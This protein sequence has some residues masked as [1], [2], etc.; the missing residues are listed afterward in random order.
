LRLWAESFSSTG[1][2]LAE[3]PEK[4][5]ESKESVGASLIRRSKTLGQKVSAGVCLCLLSFRAFVD[6]ALQYPIDAFAS[7][8]RRRKQE[9]GKAGE[10]SK[11]ATTPRSIDSASSGPD[12]NAKDWTPPTS[13]GLRVPP[14]PHPPK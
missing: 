8:I 13:R 1:D 2:V 10:E 14:F 12:S 3:D 7:L 5:K 4:A 11:A 9:E 6:L